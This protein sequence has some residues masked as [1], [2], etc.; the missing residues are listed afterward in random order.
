MSNFLRQSTDNQSRVLG[1]FIDDTDFKTPETALTINDTDVEL[2][3]DGAAPV[4][5]NSGGGTHRANG[6]YSFTFD[7]TD[8]ATVGEL[9]VSILVSG[10]LLVAKTFRVLE[11]DIYDALFADGA[12]AFDENGRVDIGA[13][14]GSTAAGDN[15]SDQYD[16]TGISGSN[17]PATQG[18]FDNLSGG[19]LTRVA[20]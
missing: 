17:F 15:I 16:G 10:A 11:E 18:Q 3:V 9:N 4:N 19:G 2:I 8:S 14:A 13:L 12:A 5:K 7:S 1:P 20:F 6:Y